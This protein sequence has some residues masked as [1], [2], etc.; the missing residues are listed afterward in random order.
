MHRSVLIPDKFILAGFL[1]GVFDGLKRFK[2]LHP[3]FLR[4]K[5][6][7]GILFLVIS[8]SMAFLI[9]VY[10]F[11]TPALYAILALNAAAIGCSALLGKIGGM[12]HCAELGGK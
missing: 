1:T 11:T 8:M 2:R 6:I 3:P 9:L 5:I 7:T 4:M 12:I 10:G